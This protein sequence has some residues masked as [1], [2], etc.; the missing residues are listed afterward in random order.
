MWSA[1]LLVDVNILVNAHRADAARHDEYEAWLINAANDAEPLGLTDE[2][3]A[4]FVRIVT[5]PSIFGDPT[6]VEVALAFTEELRTA[7]AVVRV[8]PGRRTW[9]IF[10]DTV[11]SAEARGSLIPDALLAAQAIEQGATLV[12]ADRGFARFRSLDVRHPLD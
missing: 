2:V 1:V 11:R 8:E 3:L 10:V 5:H 12:T 6:D 9:P 7:P 4:A